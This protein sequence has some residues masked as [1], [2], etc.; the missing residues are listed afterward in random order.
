MV[1]NGLLT[2]GV[3]VQAA[4][5]A[6]AG[7]ALGP[8]AEH[9]PH[10]MI[11]LLGVGVCLLV[12]WGI[13]RVLHPS[14]L[15]LR[16]APGRPNVVTP[17]HIVLVLLVWLGAT[18][19]ARRLLANRFGSEAP[20]AQ[21]LLSIAGQVP[22]IIASLFVAARTFRGGLRRGLGLSLRH[23]PWDAVRGTVGFLAVL[24]VCVGLGLLMVSILPP[25][26]IREHVMLANLD[27]VSAAW[28]A[29]IVVSAVVLA[30]LAEELFF[31]GLLQSMVRRYIGSPWAAILITSVLFALVHASLWHA[32]P[33]LFALSVALGYNYE[34]SGRLL[35][36]LLIHAAFNAVQIIARLAP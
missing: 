27:K 5:L 22:W 14:K 17:L 25:R 2:A 12:V 34:R 32:M 13:R 21:T 31:R 19:A 28:K 20:E 3:L 16:R 33:A 24:P 26:Y 18:E 4:Q 11:A 36:P 1:S 9:V 23:W 8:A 15:L 30:P 29:V 7:R 6:E 10:W 35:A